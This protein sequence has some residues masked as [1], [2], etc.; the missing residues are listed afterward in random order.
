MSPSLFYRDQAVQQQAAD[1]SATLENVRERC[2]RAA[3]AWAALA[4][5]SERGDNARLQA[6]TANLLNGTSENPDRGLAVSV[7]PRGD[8]L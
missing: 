5:R 3:I 2:Q 4:T 7:Q 8:Q 6:A 1:D